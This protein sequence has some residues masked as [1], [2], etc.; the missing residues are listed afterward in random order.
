[1]AVADRGAASRSVQVGVAQEIA[2][3]GSEEERAFRVQGRGS[4]A[5]PF[6]SLVVYPTTADAQSRQ[7]DNLTRTLALLSREAH[8]LVS[9][10]VFVSEDGASIVTL[11]RWDGRGSFDRFRETEL[12]QAAVGLVANAHPTAYWLRAHGAA[13]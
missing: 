12:G 3:A 11:A 4:V 6:I 9:T 1:M 7:A 2:K 8:G 10:E 13:S 5:E